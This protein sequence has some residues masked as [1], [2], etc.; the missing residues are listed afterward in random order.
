[1]KPAPF[2]YFDPRSLGEAV[3]L[4]EEHGAEA[5]LIAG[6]Q[7]LMPLLNMRLARPAAVVD[8]NR[9][10]G[11]DYIREEDGWLA[12]GAM[13]RQRAI[14]RSEI[15]RKRQP[16]LHAAT[17]LIAHPQIRNRGTIGGSLAHADPAAEY[18][19]VALA[20]DGQV[21]VTGPGG[22]RTIAASDLFVTYLTTSL[23]PAEIVTEARLPVLPERTGW[24]FIELSRR[25]GDFA[26]AG[27]AATLTLARGGA[28][29]DAR[30]ALFGVGATAVRATAAEALL[31][32]ERPNAELFAA[33]GAAAQREIAEPLSDIH[34]SAEYRRH[35]VG[36]L[37]RRALIQAAARAGGAS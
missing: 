7:S 9:I 18:P 24:S 15:V 11:L 3:A 28:C 34:A 32:G 13:T 25:H 17:K 36:V 20:L 5:K 10:E 26:L 4:L 1:M 12:I 29:S 14:E 2:A 16:L 22:E 35:L 33:A 30:I 31:R 23:E 19:A 8:L 27:V 21:T 37:T 6:G